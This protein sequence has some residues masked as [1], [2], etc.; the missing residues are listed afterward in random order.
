MRGVVVI[1]RADDVHCAQRHRR[2]RGLGVG[3]RVS[4]VGCRVRWSA[5]SA[6]KGLGGA[7]VVG[8]WGS[9]V[10]TEGYVALQAAIAEAEAADAAA[11]PDA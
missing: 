5:S 10:V 9:E 4:G 3:C 7:G 2:R 8:G 11:A 6:K 1:R